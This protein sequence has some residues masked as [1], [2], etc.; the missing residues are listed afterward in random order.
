MG[1][2]TSKCM[3]GSI[4]RLR[5]GLENKENEVV[6]ECECELC[7]SGEILKTQSHTRY[8]CLLECQEREEE[9]GDQGDE[10]RESKGK[11]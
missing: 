3:E 6:C 1:M 8:D 11:D 4:E 2:C 7:S 5:E 9:G 10:G